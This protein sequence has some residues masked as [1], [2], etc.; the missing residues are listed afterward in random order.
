MVENLTYPTRAAAFAER[1]QRLIESDDPAQW[2]YATLEVRFGVEA[3]LQAYVT[4]ARVTDCSIKDGW[5]IAKLAKGI[6]KA[7]KAEGNRVVKIQYKR[8]GDVVPMCSV[9]FTPVPPDLVQAAQRLGDY[10]HH[11]EERLP[12]TSDWWNDFRCRVR[13]ATAQLAAS[14][15]GEL[16]GPPLWEP[17]TRQLKLQYEFPKDDPRLEQL[18]SLAKSREELIIS[19]EYSAYGDFLGN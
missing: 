9:R 1:A 16:L 2:F 10:L 4:A 8:R 15:Q 13:K 17:S 11:R 12:Y 19:V 6:D 5:E 7:F 14:A 3:R 18:M